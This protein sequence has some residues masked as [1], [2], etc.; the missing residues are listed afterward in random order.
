MRKGLAAINRS[1]LAAGVGCVF[2]G[3]LWI[4]VLIFS[5][6]YQTPSQLISDAEIMIP[7][8]AGLLAAGY[9][10]LRKYRRGIK[11]M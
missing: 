7:V 11:Y 4:A 10:F 9:F 2:V 6:N 1:T 8:S 3:L 5:I